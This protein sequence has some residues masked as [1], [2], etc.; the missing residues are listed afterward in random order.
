MKEDDHYEKVYEATIG[1][2]GVGSIR[3]STERIEQIVFS[4]PIL[5]RSGDTIEISRE[6][7]GKIAKEI[8]RDGKTGEAKEISFHR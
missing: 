3:I 4:E 7:S 6:P 2:A 5:C 1:E 8:F